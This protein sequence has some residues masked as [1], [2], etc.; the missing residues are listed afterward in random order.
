MAKA[1]EIYTEVTNKIIAAIEAGA[2]GTGWEMP[3][4]AQGG[5]PINATTRK[6]YSGGNVL[7]LWMHAAAFDYPSN[8][9]ATYK[10]WE[11]IGAQVRKGEKSVSLIKWNPTKCKG[12]PRDHKCK[13]CGRLVPSGFAVF[14]AAQVDGYTPEP[15]P[16]ALSEDER[17]AVAEA[18]FAAVGADVRNGGGEA[19][20]M[21][22]GDYIGMPAFGD[23][24]DSARYYSTLGHEHTHWTG[25]PSRCD[26]DMKLRFG[27]EGYAAEELV[28]ELGAAFIC[29]TLG[30]DSIP[31]E[32]HAKYIANWLT[33]LRNDN[34]AIF[35]AAGKAAKALEY[36][37]E[38]V[39]GAT[40]LAA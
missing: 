4:N 23:F 10:Q 22:V 9:W 7:V 25:H 39:K 14:N 40:A 12:T 33:L 5:L 28:A 32:D 29:A 31:R 26:R 20:Y 30:I 2:D 19:F 8:E 11:G 38:Q 3:W 6:A 21:P 24:A 34:R 37:S 15:P 18:W 13:E 17:M 1:E 36:M 35:T 16:A 27:S